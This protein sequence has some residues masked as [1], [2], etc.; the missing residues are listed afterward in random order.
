MEDEKEYSILAKKDND[1][2][3][4]SSEM[5][6][7]KMFTQTRNQDLRQSKCHSLILFI[8]QKN[9]DLNGRNCI[10]GQ[11]KNILERD[12]TFQYSNIMIFYEINERET[13]IMNAFN[14]KFIRTIKGKNYQTQKKRYQPLSRRLELYQEGSKTDQN[15][16]FGFEK[17]QNLQNTQIIDKITSV[18]EQ[19]EALIMPMQE[20]SQI[21]QEKQ[22][23]N[24]NKYNN[25]RIE[26]SGSFIKV[27]I[28][29]QIY[30]PQ[31]I[32]VNNRF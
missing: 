8:I 24:S 4:M 7:Y 5:I 28:I 19:F 11:R 14:I 26:N 31:T 21:E 32:L 23:K 29:L 22:N 10:R 9:M 16:C 3:L 30:P 1:R 18:D 12:A 27:I 17:S 2:I 13:I 20:Q 6:F 15:L 25:R